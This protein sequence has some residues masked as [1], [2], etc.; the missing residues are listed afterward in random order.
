MTVSTKDQ[1]HG[2]QVKERL[3]DYLLLV[4]IIEILVDRLLT[5]GEGLYPAERTPVLL[6]LH[7]C[8]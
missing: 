2:G 6:Q 5:G 1:C 3:E 8:P 4:Q 7:P